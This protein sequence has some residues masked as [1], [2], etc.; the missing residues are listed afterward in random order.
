MKGKRKKI[1]VSISGPGVQDQPPP[2]F[3]QLENLA[4]GGGINLRGELI[5]HLTG[6]QNV[7]ETST[8]LGGGIYNKSRDVL[9]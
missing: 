5:R 9:S 1:E 3:T 6:T 4:Q 7:G 8:M 2:S